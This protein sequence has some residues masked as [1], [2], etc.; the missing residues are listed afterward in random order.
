MVIEIV[1]LA[2]IGA[3]VGGG[4]LAWKRRGAAPQK[5]LPPPAERTP[6]TIQVNDIVS[7]LGT[8]YLVETV[9]IYDDDGDEWFA[10]RLV[11]GADVVWLSAEKDDSLEVGLYHE[12]SDLTFSAPPSDTI[13]YNGVDYTQDEWGRAMVTRISASGTK[14]LGSCTYFDYEAPGGKHLSVTQWGEGEFEVSVGES[15]RP[16]MLDILPGDLVD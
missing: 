2:A 12:V 11:D 6:I 15:I 3:A 5:A 1:V 7:Y 10:Y 9:L 14:K 4:Y 8:D 13:A 16:T